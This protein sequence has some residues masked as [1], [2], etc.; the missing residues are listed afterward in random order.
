M[1]KVIFLGTSG[2]FPT[3][4]RGLPA[5]AIRRKN[6]LML[7]DCGEGTQRRMSQAKV[8]FKSKMK[9]FITHLHLLAL[10]NS[11]VFICV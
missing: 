7:F 3:A 5:I 8:G 9:I 2:S 4:K 6:E 1:L 11:G 10:V